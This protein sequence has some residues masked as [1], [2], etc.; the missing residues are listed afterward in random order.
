MTQLI[1]LVARSRNGV[2]GAKNKLPW[3]LPEDLAHFKRL[4]MDCPIIMG[5]KTFE[6]IG[7]ELPGRQMLVLSRNKVALPPYAQLAH[8][9]DGALSLCPTAPKAY[10][11]GGEQIYRAAMPLCHALVITE[12][13]IDAVGDA[14]FD[15][16]RPE[17]WARTER[18]EHHS[19]TGLAFSI[20]YYTR[21][22]Q[23]QMSA[24][25]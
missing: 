6:S 12:I 4:T 10:V 24:F 18:V 5:R 17:E 15:E 8:S 20:N 22:P 16:P 13:D 9:I 21:R 25:A 23:S 7:R 2:I 19:K 3:H 1:A 11:V 14:W